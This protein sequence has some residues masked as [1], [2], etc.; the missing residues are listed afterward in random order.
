[1]VVI[2]GSGSGKSVLVKCVIGL[3]EAD[4]ASVNVD[5]REALGAGAGFKQSTSW[6]QMSRRYPGCRRVASAIRRRSRDRV[7]EAA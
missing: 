2:D 7:W 3:I 6:R 5:G 1:M 4:G